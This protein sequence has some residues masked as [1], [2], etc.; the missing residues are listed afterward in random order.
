MSYNDD[1]ELKIGAMAEEDDDDL[2][3]G[4]DADGPLDDDV[5][6]DDEEDGM[7]EGFA[8]LDGSSY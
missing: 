2:G 8:D 3:I 6:A 5:L 4:P 7:A 1:E